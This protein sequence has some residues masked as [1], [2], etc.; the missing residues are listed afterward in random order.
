M[1]QPIQPSN[2]GA[3]NTNEVNP[4]FPQPGLPYAQGGSVPNEPPPKYEPPKQG[5]SD[6]AGTAAPYNPGYPAQ[7]PEYSAQV[8]RT[9]IVRQ[10]GLG[11]DPTPVQCPNCSAFVTTSTQSTTG[12]VTWLSAGLI[13]LFG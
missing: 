11:Q 2:Y 6:P 4:T 13:C 5:P 3:V 1:S 7:Y 10:L 12:A 8:Q 9:V